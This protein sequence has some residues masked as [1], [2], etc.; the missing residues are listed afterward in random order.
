ML[1]IHELPVWATYCSV[2]EEE[3]LAAGV[4]DDGEIYGDR[5]FR[6]LPNV[7]LA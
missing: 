6:P 7:L 3:W 1:N 5:D 4:D 2:S